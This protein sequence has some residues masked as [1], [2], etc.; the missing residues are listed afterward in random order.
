MFFDLCLT[1]TLQFDRQKDEVETP[2]NLQ[3]RE[4]KNSE[5]LREYQPSVLT[6]RLKYERLMSDIL[7]VKSQARLTK[8][9]FFSMTLRIRK[10]HENFS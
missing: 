5:I 10:N 8:K 2:I 1:L 4:Y 6:A 9:A 7:L 3:I